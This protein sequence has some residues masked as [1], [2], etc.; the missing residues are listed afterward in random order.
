M[1]PKGRK[2]F[3]LQ[4]HYGRN[5]PK[6]PSH[7]TGNRKAPFDNVG[8]VEISCNRR[9]KPLRV[10][11]HAVACS[12]PLVIALVCRSHKPRVNDSSRPISRGNTWKDSQVEFR[13]FKREPSHAEIFRKKKMKETSPSEL[14]DRMHTDPDCLEAISTNLFPSAPSESLARTVTRSIPIGLDRR[15]RTPNFALERTRSARK[16]GVNTKRSKDACDRFHYRIVG[17]LTDADA[18]LKD[19]RERKVYFT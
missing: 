12:S 17:S 11:T 16:H 1:I 3:C 15:K 13:R 14:L 18:A 4:M 10:I 19:D 8:T 2:Y 9:S 6:T 5:E 7:C